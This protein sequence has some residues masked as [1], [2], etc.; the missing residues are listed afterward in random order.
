MK[1]ENCS[2]IGKRYINLVSPLLTIF[3]DKLMSSI[4]LATLGK[5]M[6]YLPQTVKNIIFQHLQ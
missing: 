6:E 4:A 5:I 1:G 2:K 3:E